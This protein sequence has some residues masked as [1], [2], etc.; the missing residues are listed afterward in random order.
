VARFDLS[1]TQ[2][3]QNLF[4]VA[5]EQRDQ[6][7]RERF[8]AAIVDASMATT[9]GQVI[10]GPDG[11]SCFVLNLPAAGQPFVPARVT[12]LNIGS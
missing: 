6:A 4:E 7:W 1:L 11:F 12:C 5:R 2:Q 3:V 9:P 10:K 8:Y